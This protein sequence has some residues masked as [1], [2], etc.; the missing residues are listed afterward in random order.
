MKGNRVSRKTHSG[1][2]CSVQSAASALQPSALACRRRTANGRLQTADF[3]EQSPS[4]RT[5]RQL[6]LQATASLNGAAHK[7]KRHKLELN[8]KQ[9]WLCRNKSS[10]GQLPLPLYRAKS[11]ERRLASARLC[12]P[13]TSG[14]KLFFCQA[15]HSAEIQKTLFSLAR[16]LLLE[17]HHSPNLPFL[18]AMK[19]R[20][21][22]TAT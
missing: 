20:F 15:H 10:A 2:A 12:L 3:G 21:L 7:T 11:S 9:N 8:W 5:K 4:P 6:Q 18:P 16:G 14:N 17:R 22:R 1:C 19:E 13:T